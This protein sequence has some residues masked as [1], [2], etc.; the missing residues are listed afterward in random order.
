MRQNLVKIPTTVNTIG[1][2]ISGRPNTEFCGRFRRYAFALAY[3]SSASN[4]SE[5]MLDLRQTSK[6]DP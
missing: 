4:F 3:L 5:L 1:A 2:T 6:I